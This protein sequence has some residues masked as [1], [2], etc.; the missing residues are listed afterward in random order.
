MSGEAPRD[1][2]GEPT[3]PR[4]LTLY[5]RAGCHLCDDALATIEA[6]RSRLPQ[7]L[8]EVI[9][10]DS[11]PRLH[12]AYFERIPVLALDGRELCEYFVE[13]GTLLGALG[14]GGGQ[15]DRIAP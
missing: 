15:R 6:T 7:F 1:G 4:R 11:E 2:A 12:D 8:L 3:A 13:E 10:I 9:D 14:A 5:S